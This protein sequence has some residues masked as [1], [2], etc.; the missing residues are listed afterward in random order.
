M[1][2]WLLDIVKDSGRCRQ[3]AVKFW[4]QL[5]SCVSVVSPLF[6]EVARDA[7]VQEQYRRLHTRTHTNA[8]TRAHVHIPPHTTACTH[9]TYTHVCTHTAGNSDIGCR[10]GHCHGLSMEAEPRFS[11]AAG[12]VV[13]SHK[14]SRLHRLFFRA[15]WKDTYKEP[16]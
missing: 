8:H 6:L 5:T 10:L 13:L 9:T 2:R 3:S 1:V 16:F 7:R 15:I 14:W 4:V 11:P 12:G